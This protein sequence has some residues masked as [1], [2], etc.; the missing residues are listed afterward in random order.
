MWITVFKTGTHTNNAGVEQSYT[1]NDLVEI[2]N[3]YNNQK[4]EDRHTA[5]LIP[6]DHDK[7]IKFSDGEVMIKPSMGWVEQL[8]VD[9]SKLLAKINPTQKFMEAVAGKYYNKLSIS[10]KENK[11]L[12]HIALLGAVNP[13]VKGLP[14]LNSSFTVGVAELTELTHYEFAEEVKQENNKIPNSKKEDPKM[15]IITIDPNKLI[16]WI[17]NEFGDEAATK[18]QEKL[19]EFKAEA[20]KEETAP[21]TETPPAEAGGSGNFTEEQK[22]KFAEQQSKIEALESKLRIA[23]FSEDVSKTNIPAGLKPLAIN[24]LEIAHNSGT[25]NFSVK[26]EAGKSISPIEAVKSLYKSWPEPVPTG[27]DTNVTGGNFSEPDKLKE[28]E[29]ATKAYNERKK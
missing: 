27:A 13:A 29:E 8:K 6:G 22:K 11:L 18:V 16:D 17:K 10:L 24:I 20:P 7:V 15:E 14:E 21:E 19:S 5:P 28:I 2:A 12:D 3:V 25:S 1:E 9:G 26:D 4:D 23:E